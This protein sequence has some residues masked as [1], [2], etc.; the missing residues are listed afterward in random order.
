MNPKEIKKIIIPSYPKGTV[1]LGDLDVI[2][3]VSINKEIFTKSNK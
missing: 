1:I 3:S 2:G